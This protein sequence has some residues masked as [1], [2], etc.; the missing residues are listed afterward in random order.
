MLVCST[1]EYFTIKKISLVQFVLSRAAQEK[2]EQ[3]VFFRNLF[4][5][6]LHFPHAR[7]FFSL[8][9]SKKLHINAAHS[10]LAATL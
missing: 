6:F 5:F 8:D 9:Y 1:E 7:F 4:F 10:A 2:T 3:S